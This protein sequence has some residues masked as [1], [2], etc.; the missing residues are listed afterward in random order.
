MS[1]T[2]LPLIEE[3][4]YPAFQMM[5]YELRTISYREL[6]VGHQREIAYRRSRNGY[7]ELRVSAEEF[8]AWLKEDERPANLIALRLFIDNK[9]ARM[10]KRRG[11]VH[12]YEPAEPG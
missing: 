3:N 7:I 1:P 6:L 4:D 12:E 11:V 8:S 9:G 2:L 10:A 5:L